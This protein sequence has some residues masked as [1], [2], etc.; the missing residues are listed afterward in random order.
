MQAELGGLGA[1]TGL[2]DDR[3]LRSAEPG[4]WRTDLDAARHAVKL[5]EP[6][7]LA[8][9]GGQPL[10]VTSV[11]YQLADPAR[12]IATVRPALRGRVFPRALSR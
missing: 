2:E 11:D 9:E 4:F 10:R 1:G 12:H 5:G 8:P 6:E 3:G 7:H